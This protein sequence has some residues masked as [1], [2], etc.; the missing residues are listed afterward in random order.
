MKGGS[1]VAVNT[2][3]GFTYEGGIDATGRFR[4]AVDDFADGQTFFMQAYDRKGKTF[5][6]KVI[7]DPEIYPGV[8]NRLKTG[9]VEERLWADSISSSSVRIASDGISVSIGENEEKNYHL[10]EIEVAAR[11]RKEAP[12][13]QDFYF[14][15]KITE[16]IIRKRS[17]PDILPY[18]QDLSGIRVGKVSL[19]PSAEEGDLSVFRYA[20]FT[21]RGA[22]VLRK[23]SDPY[24]RQPGELPVLL[25]GSLVDTHHVLTTLDPQNVASIE[26]LT[27]GQ[28]LAYTSFGFDGAILITTRDYRK[29]KPESKG[30]LWQ[31]LGLSPADDL[32]AQLPDSL[33]LP[34]RPGAYRLIVEGIDGLGV[35]RYEEKQ[36]VV[37]E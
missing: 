11:I 30:I 34:R 29:E 6:Y 27:P 4:V 24:Q 17:Y 23:I 28:A 14:Q 20:I 22:A 21:T 3:T 33:V 35:P 1:L 13:T 32:P 31:P 5:G 25:D 9:R 8:D 15:R 10:P 16:E 12:E 37:Q 36:I 2:D 18:L 26:R 7:P 19:N